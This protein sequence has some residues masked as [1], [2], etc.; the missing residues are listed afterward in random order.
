MNF[1]IWIWTLATGVCFSLALYW[2]PYIIK[3]GWEDGKNA[4]V[5]N[6]KVC[7]VCFKNI[8]AWNAR[9]KKIK[10]DLHL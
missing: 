9:S 6:A 5:K 1:T 7:D 10:K 3:K 4:S 2:W 8:A